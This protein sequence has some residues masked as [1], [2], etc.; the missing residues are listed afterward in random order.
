MSKSVMH[1]NDNPK[2][3]HPF[4]RAHAQ[5]YRSIRSKIEVICNDCGWSLATYYNKLKGE[6]ILTEMESLIVASVWNINIDDIEAFQKGF[7]KNKK[8]A[9]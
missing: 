1:I 3:T 9:A 4:K 7:K 2:R 8:R 6:E 5:A